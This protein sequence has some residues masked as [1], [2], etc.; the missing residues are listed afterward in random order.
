MTKDEV[1]DLLEVMGWRTWLC[2]TEHDEEYTYL[3]GTRRH[4]IYIGGTTSHAVI[5]QFYYAGELDGFLPTFEKADPEQWG[6][7]APHTWGCCAFSAH[8]PLPEG[9]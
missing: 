1:A 6:S 5:D 3:S 7:L 8:D 4:L 2:C 9:Q